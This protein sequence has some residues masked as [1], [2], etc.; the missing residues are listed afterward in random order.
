MT[1][2]LVPPHSPFYWFKHSFSSPF[3][4]YIIITAVTP[5]TLP[6]YSIPL[7]FTFRVS[8]SST[9]TPTTTTIAATFHLPPLLSNS[10]Y[11]DPV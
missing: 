2:G 10:I 3:H 4:F 6:N 5:I 1:F 11:E 7:L 8:T 9:P